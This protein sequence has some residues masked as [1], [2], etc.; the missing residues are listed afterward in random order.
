MCKIKTKFSVWRTEFLDQRNSLF[1]KQTFEKR[2][3]L[4]VWEKDV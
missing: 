1:G 3:E 4:Y 2:K